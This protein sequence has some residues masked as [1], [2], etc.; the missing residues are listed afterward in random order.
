MNLTELLKQENIFLADSFE[1]TDAF[2]AA[3]ADFLH[4]KNIIDDKEGIKRLFVKRE[5]VHSTAIGKGA[6]APHIFSKEFSRFLFTVALIKEGVDFKAQD[7]QKIYLVFLIMSAE[8]E[9]GKHLKTLAHIARLIKSTEVVEKVKEAADA[10][11]VFMAIK[12]SEAQI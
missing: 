9:V 1:D 4:Q 6:A 8:R 2:Y 3:F 5:N 7:E 11:A 10:E 12:E